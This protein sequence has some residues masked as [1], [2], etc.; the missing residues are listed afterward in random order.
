M[1]INDIKNGLRVDK[2]MV[3]PIFINKIIVAALQI[4]YKQKRGVKEKDIRNS[5]IDQMIFGLYAS[6]VQTKIETILAQMDSHDRHQHL[7]DTLSLASRITTQR[8]Y[9]A[10]IKQIKLLLPAYFE[11]ESVGVLLLDTK[12]ND[13][14]TI[15]DIDMTEEELKNGQEYTASKDIISFPSTL[16]ITGH[17][18]QQGKVFICNEVNKERRFMPDIDNLSSISEPFNFLIG[19]IYDSKDKSPVG[20]IQ[21]VNKRNKKYINQSDIQRFEIIQELLGR[22]VSNT[23]EI[24]ELINVTIGF[25]SSLGSIKDLANNSVFEADMSIKMKK[26][27]VMSSSLN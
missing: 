3:T 2:Y 14:F 25:K 20:V 16:G 9:R 26:M 5:N 27:K 19:P 21:L 23:A 8:S 18:F 24:H 6:V 11:F 22:S 10:L 13:L 12:T 15:A 7:F 17:A 1:K 4:E